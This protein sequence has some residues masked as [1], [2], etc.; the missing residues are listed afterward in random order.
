MKIPTDRIDLGELGYKDYWIEMPRSVKEGFLHEIGKTTPSGDGNDGEAARRMN[1][2]VLEL[3][4]DWNIDDDEG[5]VFPVL[6]KVKTQTEKEKI[7]A[8]LPVDIIVYCAQRIAGNVKVP[9]RVAD[10]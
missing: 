8:E 6:S 10:F 9:E 1:I 3:I 5:K 2:K 4:T 7:V